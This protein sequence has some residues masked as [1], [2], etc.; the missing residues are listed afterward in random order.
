MVLWRILAAKLLSY[1]F[2]GCYVFLHY[3]CTFL[4]VLLGFSVLSIILLVMFM[5]FL[6]SST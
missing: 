4:L 2:P 5:Y 6:V 1:L 3:L